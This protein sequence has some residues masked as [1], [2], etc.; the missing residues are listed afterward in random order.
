MRVTVAESR[1]PESAKLT[2]PAAGQL[3]AALLGTDA[4]RV[5]TRDLAPDGRPD[6]HVRLL[7]LNADKPLQN[8]VLTG[9]KEGRWEHVE[10]GRWW[11]VACERQGRQ[12]DVYFQFWAAGIINVFIPSGGGQWAAQGPITMEAAKMMGID[13]IRSAMMVAWGDQWTN[14]IQPFWA[15]PLLGLAGLSA[16][17]IMGYTTVTLLYSGVVLS[18]FALLVGFGI[19]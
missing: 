1:S 17:D 16:R 15:L 5:G 13:P 18:I 14:M 8:V 11:R 9:P 6:C 7:G 19:W 3:T 4:D 12:L 10:T 2:E